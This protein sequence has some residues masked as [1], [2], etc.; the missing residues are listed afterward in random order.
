[1]LGD[2]VR[3]RQPRRYASGS[4]DGA[5]PRDWKR[6]LLWLAAA[7]LLPLLIG[8]L[9]A[10]YVIFPP[11]EMTGDGVAVPDLIGLDASAAQ[12]ELVAAG[13]GDMQTEQL[14]HPEAEPGSIIAQSPLPGQQLRA[15]SD[16]RIAVSSGPPRVVIPDV[17]GFSAERAASMLSRAGFQVTRSEQES[18]APA[19][20]VIRTDPEPGQGLVLPAAVTLI[21][22]AGPPALPQPGALPDTTPPPR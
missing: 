18:P 12:R 19:G 9:I 22:S 2:S 4:D 16:V 21:V 17:L 15:G 1:M 13:L 20:R 14:P 5:P 6:S 11:T 10:V 7:L 3:R 8:W